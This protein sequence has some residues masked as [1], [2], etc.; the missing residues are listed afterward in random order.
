MPSGTKGVSIAVLTAI[1]LATAACGGSAKK[2]AAPPAT[3]GTGSA[4]AAASAT[5]TTSTTSATSAASSSGAPTGAPG[6][7][8]TTAQISKLLLTDKD[9]AGY[10]FNAS[11]DG[12]AVTTAQD[13]VTTGGAACQAFVDA[14]E[15]LS[16]KYGTTAEVDRQLTKPNVAIGI[17]SSVIAFPSADKAAAMISDLAAA[18]KTCKNLAITQSSTV[19]VVMT[20]SAIPELTKDGQAGYIDYMSAGGKTELM[21]AD[22]VHVGTAVSVVAFIGPM[23]NDPALLQQMGGKQLSHL[24][25][26]QVGRL[27]TAQ[28]LS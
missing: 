27:K 18:L 14:E 25:D 22:L 17:E 3:S 24:S 23:S 19:S 11:Q 2:T 21:A 9:D 7:S 26:V 12:T 13:A 1:V 15:A 16:T 20:P 28:G 4:T 5:S 10:T 8:L 6:G